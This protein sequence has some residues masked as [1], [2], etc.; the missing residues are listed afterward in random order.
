MKKSEALE[1]GFKVL[2]VYAFIQG[3]TGLGIP[4]SLHE[5][6]NLASAL[7]SRQGA[8]IPSTFSVA[9]FLPSVL[10]FLLGAILWLNAKK[11]EVGS[12]AQESDAGSATGLNPQI[13]QSIIFSALGIFIIIES[14]APL[15]NVATTLNVYALA[16]HDN[17]LFMAP[18]PYFRLIEG[19]VKLSFGCWL[20]IGSRSLRRFKSWFP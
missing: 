5:S 20:I 10:L 12:L 4:I 2:S 9:L 1:V 15:A 17:R 3:I 11:T 13:L 19:L 6:Q 8:S 18:F 16:R 7:A 14:V